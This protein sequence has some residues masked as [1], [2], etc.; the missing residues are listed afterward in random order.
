MVHEDG[1][2]VEVPALNF[3]DY[4][5]RN[6]VP[7]DTVIVRCDIE[8]AEYEVLKSMIVTGT[9]R[10]VDYM[11]V[12]WHAMLSPSLHHLKQVCA[13]GVCACAA[14]RGVTPHAAGRHCATVAAGRLR[15]S[16]QG[17]L[18]LP[19]CFLLHAG[20]TFVTGVGL[21]LRSGVRR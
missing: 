17:K 13:R 16:S 15:H 10:L 14:V 12:E 21:L 20:V 2:R 7:E 19:P 5:A 3:S 11:D 8:G 6:F 1:I 9:A 4:L 18:P